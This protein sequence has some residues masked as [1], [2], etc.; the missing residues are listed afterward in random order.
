[1]RFI[2]VHGHVVPIRDGSSADRNTVKAANKKVLAAGRNAGGVALAGS[3]GYM[4]LAKHPSPMGIVASVAA[5][6]FATALGHI[7]AR[8]V[9]SSKVKDAR[10]R[11]K[12][13]D[14]P[15]VKAP[16]ASAAKALAI[17]GAFSVGLTAAVIG[18]KATLGL[19]KNFA[20][21]AHSGAAGKIS[22]LARKSRIIFKARHLRVVK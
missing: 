11:V 6:S 19:A 10:S 7:G 9:E 4:T 5:P 14:A 20:K 2:R 15:G 12:G 1:M 18:P 22:D 8:A 16:L 17:T 3:L 21:A 13:L